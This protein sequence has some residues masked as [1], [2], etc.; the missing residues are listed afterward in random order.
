[1]PPGVDPAAKIKADFLYQQIKEENPAS[2]IAPQQAIELLGTMQG[3]YNVQ[4]L[5][6]L[7]DDPRWASSA[8]EQLSATLLIFEKFKDVEEKAKQGNAWAQKVIQS[9][10]DAEWFLRR[11]AL[12]EKITLKVFKVTGKPILMICPLRPRHGHVR[13][14]LCMPCPCCVIRAT[15]SARMN[16]EAAG[17]YDS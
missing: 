8:A 5:I 11:P 14:F 13:I 2:I 3:G 4:P 6:H 15:A 7:L 9:W 12:P 17:R 10:A 1:V 16:R